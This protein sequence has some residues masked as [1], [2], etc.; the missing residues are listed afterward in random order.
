MLFGSREKSRS[1]NPG[2]AGLFQCLWQTRNA[3]TRSNPGIRRTIRPAISSVSSW[4]QSLAAGCSVTHLLRPA[5]AAEIIAAEVI[6]TGKL[7]GDALGMASGDRD[8]D[9]AA[10]A[11]RY[12]AAGLSL[13]A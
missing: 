8:Q 6:H 3:G 11:Q 7:E 9:S 13:N 5:I 4:T 1:G 10:G 12:Q 2:I